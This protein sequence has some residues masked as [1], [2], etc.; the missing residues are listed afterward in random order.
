[1]IPTG[2][3][4]SIWPNGGIK[5]E[6]SYFHSKAKDNRVGGGETSYKL[7]ED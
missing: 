6:M 7:R 3:R 4:Q 5:S 1:V 2:N